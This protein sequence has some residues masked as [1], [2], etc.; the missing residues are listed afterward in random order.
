MCRVFP[1]GASH[2]ARAVEPRVPRARPVKATSGPA[3]WSSR[4]LEGQV[5]EP[6]PSLG[7]SLP[8][9]PPGDSQ[10]TLSGSPLD[11][12]AP[13]CQHRRPSQAPE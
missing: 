4:R 2:R 13:T 12:S 8:L 11:G 5:R 3:V 9:L 7:A 6:A 10:D 1:G